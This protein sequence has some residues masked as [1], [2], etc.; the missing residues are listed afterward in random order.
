MPVRGP[1][2]AAAPPGPRPRPRRRRPRPAVGRLGLPRPGV[3]LPRRLLRLSALPQ[4]RPEPARLHR[5]LLRPGRRAVHRPGQLPDGLR[6]PDLRARRCCTPW[7][8][9]SCRLVFQY[10]IGLALAVFFHQ[11]FRLS[12]TL[13]ALFLVPWL[14]PLI[15]S[16]S[17]WSWMLNSDSGIVNAALQR[18]RRRPGEL[19]D[20][21]VLVAGLGD[22]RQHLDRRPVQP[23]RPLQRPAVHPR[24][25]CTRPPPSTARA[26]G[27]GSGASPSRCCARSPRSPCCSGLVYTLKVFDIIW[28]MTKGGPADSSTT[29]ATWSYQLGFGNLL[30][31]L[32]PRRGGRQPAG[33]RRPGLRPGLRP[34][35][36]KAGSVT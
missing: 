27:S 22:H 36:A 7:C 33:R 23:G 10:A 34:R 15:V 14:L 21:A 5:P 2:G 13:R 9:P 32:R 3:A 17:T 30:P 26:P 20:L 6:R 16:A 19:A 4:H 18:R 31:A 29:F 11:H 12:A 25:A 1:D 35:P 28:I 24:R 8:S